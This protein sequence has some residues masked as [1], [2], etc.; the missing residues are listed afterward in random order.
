MINPFK[1]LFGP[2]KEELATKRIE[3]L[4]NEETRGRD[5]AFDNLKSDLDKVVAKYSELKI[6]NILVVDGGYKIEIENSF[7]KDS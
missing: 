1:S 6:Q 5:R 7:F 4:L 2:S 3:L